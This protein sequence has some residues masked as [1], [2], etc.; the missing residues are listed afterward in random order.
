MKRTFSQHTEI[1]QLTPYDLL[2][3][4]AEWF[5]LVPATDTPKP[6]YGNRPTYDRLLPAV[7]T[8]NG[9]SRRIPI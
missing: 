1:I 7:C 5:F 3:P 9:N 4:L 2:P 8:M 6:T